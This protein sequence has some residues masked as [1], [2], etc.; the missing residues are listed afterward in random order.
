M[1]THL[2]AWSRAAASRR[3]AAFAFLIF[4][5]AP[6]PA[7]ALERLCDPGGEDCRA[8]LINY[9]RAETV[10]IDVG[11]WFME[12]A[13]Y[14]AEL[15]KKWQAGVQVRVLVDPRANASTPLNADRLAELQAA[16]IPMRKRIASGILH[17]K[18]MLFAGQGIVEFSGANYSADAWRPSDLT[19]PYQ[20]YTDES[21]YFTNDASIVHSFMTKYDDLWTNTSSYANY[22][23]VS[24]TLAREYPLYT[25]DADLNFPPAES[26]AS[27]AISRYNAETQKIDVIMYR[28]TDQ[29]HTNAMIAAKNRGIPVRLITDPDQYR[30]A[31]RLWDAWNVD[32]M[33]VAGIP[34]KMRAHAG[35]N[36]QKLVL[37][38]GQGMAIF[39]SSNWTSPSDKSQEE[40]NYFTD[41]SVLFTWLVN[42]F[43][44]KWNN[45][46]GVTE[47][48]A[49]V[50]LAPDKATTPSPANLATGVG[51]SSVTLK[52]YGGPWAHRYDVYLGTTSTTLSLVL[53]DKELG[54]SETTKEMQSFT[55]TNLLPGTTYYWRVVSRT[56][57][58]MTK[59]SDL[60]SFTTAGSP[61]APPAGET[62]LPTPWVSRDIGSV[63]APGGSAYDTAAARFS[64]TGAG[65]DVW[66]SADALHFTYVPLAGDG[67]ITARVASIQNVN[68][69]TKAGVMI[70][71]TLSAGSAQAFMLVSPSKGL[72]FQRRP[73]AGGSS[74]NTAGGTGT[75]P[76]YVRLVRS[77]STIS[78]YRSTNGST[79]TLVGTQTIAMGA[80]VFM[81]LGVSSHV[82]GTTAT[83][84]FDHITV[85]N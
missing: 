7:R 75:A 79:W 36:H 70:R 40:H 33:Y 2:K 30:D 73:V 24:G 46:A 8:I 42:Q 64:V 3:L 22:A 4:L 71:E 76:Y 11:F 16:G 54:P 72:A 45:S 17:Y 62:A 83:A 78:A 23:N 52:W 49:F 27:R 53:T 28:I 25:K 10:G 74:V 14:S 26:Y 60:W 59:T 43:E 37:L 6:T 41:K 80:N 50:P 61:G 56:M 20:N 55:V 84:T 67:S 77:G 66:G 32:R 13:R 34:I 47:N 68:A 44:R 63:G 35:L 31:S 39:G 9:I 81:G 19:Q 69:W 15:I 48:K 85:V 12:D 18:M 5:V 1:G 29:R 65:A 57:A 82:T 21:I 51:T 38:H 58:N